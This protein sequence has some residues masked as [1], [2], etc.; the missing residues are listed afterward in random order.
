MAVIILLQDEASQRRVEMSLN[1]IGQFTLDQLALGRYPT[2]KA[3]ADV[4]PFDFK[5]LNN[6]IIISGT[7]RTRRDFLGGNRYRF[8]NGQLFRFTSLF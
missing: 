7:S 4:M 3:I 6:P 2:F 1:G 8:V 5:P